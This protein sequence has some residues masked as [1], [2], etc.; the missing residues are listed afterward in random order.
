MEEPQGPVVRDRRRLDPETGAVR[1]PRETAAAGP[2]PGDQSTPA[3]TDELAT[4]RTQLAERT[5]D[6]QRL[7]AEYLNYKRRVDRDRE[8]VRASAAASV[9][10]A[11]LP[12]LDDLDR[13]RDHGQLEGGFKAV[14]DSLERI[15][16][17]HGLTRF[18]AP[19]DAFD[20]HVHE[21]LMHAYADEESEL[22]G[23][24]AQT[25]LQTGYRVG[26]RVIRPAR[27]AV[28][29]PAHQAE[30]EPG[31]RPGSDPAGDTAAGPAGDT[32]GAPA[33]NAA[34][35]TAAG[36]GTDGPDTPAQ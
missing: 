3:D 35:D 6:L 7:Q 13:A 24:V 11:L 12:V 5:A 1:E 36:P 20:P 10:T 26:D 19:G 15:L 32:A 4:V 27:V 16:A 30:P 23:P 33:G 9:L 22:A 29:E 2:A 28:L 34:G 31:A 17:T 18:G 21:A 25:I 8:V 14:A